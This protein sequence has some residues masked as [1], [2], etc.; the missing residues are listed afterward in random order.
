M[1]NIVKYRY[2]YFG[3]SLLIIIPGLLALLVWGLPPRDRLHGW[4]PWISASNR[5]PVQNPPRSWPC[6]H[7]MDTWIHKPRHLVRLAPSSARRRWT[8]LL[9]GKL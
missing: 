3:L 8:N 6:T 2:Y 4:K 1:I 5:A 7:K 9:W